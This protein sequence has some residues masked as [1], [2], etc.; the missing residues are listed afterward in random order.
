MQLRFIRANAE[1]PDTSTFFFEPLQPVQ[2]I[3]GQ[4]IKIEVEGTYGP[5]EHRFTISAAPHTKTIAITTRNSDSPYKKRLFTLQQ[6]AEVR[7][8]AIEGDFIWRNTEQP[9]IW[10]AAGI[11][12]TP[13]YAMLQDRAHKKLP[14]EATLFY[15]S[16]EPIF[17][18]ELEALANKHT[19]FKC[20][21]S[22][23]RTP[24]QRILDEPNALSRFTYISGPSIMVDEISTALMQKGI[25]KN[26][27]V[28]D[29]FTGRF[30][31]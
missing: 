5:L 25:T 6:G 23:N 2:W 15:N 21:Y 27:L 13:F 7:A 14:I 24:A 30:Q 19:E 26:Q 8:F 11:G 3:A 28:R 12:I 31:D 17:K 4:S 22:A 20:I 18:N 16:R 10:I 1:T 29:W 9:K